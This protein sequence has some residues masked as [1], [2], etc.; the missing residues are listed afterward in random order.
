MIKDKHGDFL[1]SACLLPF[2][3]QPATAPKSNSEEEEIQYC[4]EASPK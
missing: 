2:V 1:G 4:I 3:H